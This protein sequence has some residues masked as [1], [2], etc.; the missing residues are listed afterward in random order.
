MVGGGGGVRWIGPATTPAAGR[1]RRPG[2]RREG[3]ERSG[4]AVDR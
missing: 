1:G 2:S 4:R 3:H